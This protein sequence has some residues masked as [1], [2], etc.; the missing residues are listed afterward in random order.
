MEHVETDRDE[1][2]GSAIK[3][4]VE[5]I[6]IT[7]ED[8]RALVR[9]YESQARA[10]HAGLSDE[11]IRL[12]VA[13]TIIKRYAKLAAASGGATSLAGVIPGIGTALSITGGTLA[14]VSLSVKFQV[15]MTMCLAMTLKGELTNED[16]KHLSFIIALTGALEGAGTK[17]G[18]KLVSKAGQRMVEQYLKGAT[19]IYIKE[20]FKAVGIKLTKSGILKAIPFGVGVAIGSGTGYAMTRYVG[21]TARD[22]FLLDAD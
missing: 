1:A 9:Q 21:R 18:T 10:R 14:D 17:G 6:A 3:K 19:L 2:T 5:A 7:P 12:K 4:F 11:Q 15:D 16:A 8:A 20:L 22:F 13:D